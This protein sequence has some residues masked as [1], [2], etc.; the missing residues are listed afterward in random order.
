MPTFG[1]RAAT[2][3]ASDLVQ[4]FF[5]RLLSRDR[6]S[7]VEEG[8]GPFRAWLLGALRNHERD[9]IAR[10]QAL[11]RGG[12]A[13]PIRIDSEEG[14]DGWSSRVSLSTT[15]PERSIAHGL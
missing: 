2:P 3:I 6:L 7:T 14:S 5:A 12:G 1:G 8:V 15:L 10:E 13:P 11:K 9:E 4:G